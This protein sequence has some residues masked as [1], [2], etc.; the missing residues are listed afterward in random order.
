MMYY[1]GYGWFGFFL[2]LIFWIAVIWLIVWIIQ[3]ATKNKESA[4]DILEKRF[5]KGEINKKEY[6]EKKK[7]LK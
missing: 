4:L 3:Q 2:M 6:L 1:Y 5:A 7:M